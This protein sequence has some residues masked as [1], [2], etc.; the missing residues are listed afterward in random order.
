MKVLKTL[1]N[2]LYLRLKP[3]EEDSVKVRDLDHINGKY[4]SAVHQKYN[5]NLTL[6]KVL[7]TSRS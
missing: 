6:T 3:L 5:L 1:I 2:L 4:R 7:F